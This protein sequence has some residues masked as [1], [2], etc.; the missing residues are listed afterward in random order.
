[1]KIMRFNSKKNSL[2]NYAA[3]GSLISTAEDLNLWNKWF[4]SGQI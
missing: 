2:Q 3:A 1:M 4:Y